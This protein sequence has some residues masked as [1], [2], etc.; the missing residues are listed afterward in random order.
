MKINEKITDTYD[1][2]E[3]IGSGGTVYKAYHKRL[4]MYTI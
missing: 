4:H 1:V 3:D 2:L